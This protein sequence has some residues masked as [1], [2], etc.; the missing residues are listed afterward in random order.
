MEEYHPKSNVKHTLEKLNRSVRLQAWIKENGA[1]DE[2]YIPTLY[3]PS[4]WKSPPASDEIENNLQRFASKAKELVSNNTSQPKSN[5][6]KLQYTCLK[7][8]K[9]DKR[10]IICLSDKN[11]G[12]VIME[13]D[14]YFKHCLEDHLYCR[15]TYRQLTEEEATQRVSLTRRILNQLRLDHHKD[16]SDSENK[17][18][19]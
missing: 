5:L 19:Q 8:I 14:T 1:S 10:F 2:D 7:K 18:F 13:R 15:T 3:M 9:N 17:Y 12:P 4:P 16:L 6:R 11:L